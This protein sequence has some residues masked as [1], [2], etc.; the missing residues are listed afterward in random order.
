MN[1][2]STL[3]IPKRHLEQESLKTT[4]SNI[5]EKDVIKVVDMSNRQTQSSTQKQR[6]HKERKDD[7]ELEIEF[8]FKQ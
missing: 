5:N 6:L 8:I 4:F 3:R 7:T 2:L 1:I